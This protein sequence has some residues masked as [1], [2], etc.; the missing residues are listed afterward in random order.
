[1]YRYSW[2]YASEMFNNM[3]KLINKAYKIEAYKMLD[4]FIINFIR[5]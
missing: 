3:D 5:P 1:M 4:M 2:F